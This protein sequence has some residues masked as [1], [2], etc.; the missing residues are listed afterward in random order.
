MTN[1]PLYERFRDLNFEGF[2]RLAAEPSLSINNRIGF[3]DEY[4]GI[5]EAAIFQDIR[6]TLPLLAE[7]GRTVLDIGPGCSQ[8]PDLLVDLCRRRGFSIQI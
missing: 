5:F 6:R 4:R 3:P 2:R 7:T 8:L 1:D